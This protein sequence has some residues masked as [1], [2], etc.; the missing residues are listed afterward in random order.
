MRRLRE[1]TGPA[2]L[3]LAV[4][5][6]VVAL[7]GGAYAASS[8]NGAGKA[9]A[10]AKAKKGPRGPKGPKGDTGAQGPAGPTGPAG[11]AG[12]AG[13]KGDKGD[14]GDTGNT[15]SP[16]TPGK[17]VV[18]TPIAS[19]GVKCEGFGGVEVKVEGAGSGTD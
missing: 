9:T 11:P 12:S 18:T 14:K 1:K 16:G 15:G 10:S 5:A 6:L 4:T 2:G 19:G 8:D 17:S 13:A 3:I 7:T